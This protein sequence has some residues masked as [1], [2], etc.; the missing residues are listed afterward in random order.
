M[1]MMDQMKKDLEYVLEGHKIGGIQTASERYC[2][3]SELRDFKRWEQIAFRE[4][5]RKAMREFDATRVE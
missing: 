1:K 3:I 4:A 2:E 5:C